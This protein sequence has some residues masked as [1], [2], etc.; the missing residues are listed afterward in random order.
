MVTTN[1]AGTDPAS[2]LDDAVRETRRLLG[3][4][5]QKG[6]TSQG[7]HIFAVW[8]EMTNNNTNAAIVGAVNVWNRRLM[9]TLED[10]FSIITPGAF[11][12]TIKPAAGNYACWFGGAGFRISRWQVALREATGNGVAPSAANS[13]AN[14]ISNVAD[15]NNAGTT[16][17]T[18]SFAHGFGIITTDGTKSYC[19]DQMHESLGGGAGNWGRLN[20]NT[21]AGA[22]NHCDAFA[23]L[24][25]LG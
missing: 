20:P 25:K 8:K 22:P 16:A 13:I 17:D 9:G 19:L 3:A 7:N 23:V 5:M 11:T 10:P 1:P 15:S 18:P 12:Q 2:E 24:F 6:H 21:F 14:I 4:T